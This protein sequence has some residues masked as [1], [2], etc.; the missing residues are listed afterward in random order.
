MMIPE[1]G[2]RKS[3]PGLGSRYGGLLPARG[4]EMRRS[5]WDSDRREELT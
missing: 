5:Y 4:E 3:G 1:N 2:E